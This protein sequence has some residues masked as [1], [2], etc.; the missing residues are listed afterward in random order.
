MSYYQY[1]RPG[2][3]NLDSLLDKKAHLLR[4]N[5]MEHYDFEAILPEVWRLLQVWY[6]SESGL[7]PIIR[8]VCFDRRSNKFFVDLYLEFNK[9]QSTLLGE[10]DDTEVHSLV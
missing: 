4:H 5:L 2:P 6:G 3:I 7:I 10:D 9:E 8:P 1:K